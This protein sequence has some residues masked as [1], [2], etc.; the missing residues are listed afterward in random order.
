MATA[1]E[2]AAANPIIFIVSCTALIH[3]AVSKPPAVKYIVITAPPI[4]QPIH[5]PRR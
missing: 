5:G 4:T 2:N 1:N 3:A